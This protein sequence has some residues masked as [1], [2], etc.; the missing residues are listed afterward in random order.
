MS[1]WQLWQ[2]GPLLWQNK[3]KRILGGLRNKE[4]PMRGGKIRLYLMPQ[5]LRCDHPLYLLHHG[6]I[7]RLVAEA[8][9]N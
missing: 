1:A 5:A 8:I 6:I 2:T 3:D 4:V 7:H 9:D